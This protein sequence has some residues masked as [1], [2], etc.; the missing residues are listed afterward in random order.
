MSRRL[1]IASLI[2]AL[3]LLVGGCATPAQKSSSASGSAT[4]Q[5]TAKAKPS[6]ENPTLP[7][8]SDKEGEQRIETFQHFGTGVALDLEDKPDQPLDEYLKST[9]KDVSYE[10]L[11]LEAARRLI[12]NN[13][14]DG[15]LRLLIRGS[16]QPNASGEL[17]SWL[18]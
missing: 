17:Y 7:A 9:T 3:L 2:G 15:A 16:K 10:P 14:F 18:G 13:K 8:L 11:V 4:K 5:R 1:A 6:A 12:R